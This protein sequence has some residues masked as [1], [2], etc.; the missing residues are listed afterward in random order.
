[1]KKN[2]KKR[3]ALTLAAVS[4]I[5]IGA[6]TMSKAQETNAMMRIFGGLRNIL[7]GRSTS[8]GTSYLGTP[9]TVSLVN[10]SAFSNNTKTHKDGS[11]TN[12]SR[13][14]TGSTGAIN[15]GKV[16]SNGTPFQGMPK[17]QTQVDNKAFDKHT[18][19]HKVQDGV[20]TAKKVTTT[21][22]D[23]TVHPA[24]QTQMK[25]LEKQLATSSKKT[26]G[27]KTSGK[28][29]STVKFQVKNLNGNTTI[30]QVK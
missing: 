30:T 23:V 28:K 22:S 12:T 21:G 26:S 20:Y 24:P 13:G 2:A 9:K 14:L 7:T 4:A 17:N 1:M 29:T 6:A 16:T 11:K 18:N 5:G 8:T 19:E 10:N 27:S 25:T 15:S 3:I